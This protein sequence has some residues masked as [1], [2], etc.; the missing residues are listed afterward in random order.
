MEAVEF[1]AGMEAIR[2]GLDQL[3]AHKRLSPVCCH[4]HKDAN[5]SQKRK[6]DSACPKRPAGYTSARGLNLSKLHLL[7]WMPIRSICAPIF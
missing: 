2:Q 5:G 7:H 3:L 4:D 1:H 6:N